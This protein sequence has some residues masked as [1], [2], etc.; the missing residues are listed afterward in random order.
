L[1]KNIEVTV[2]FYGHFNQ[3][4]GELVEVVEAPPGTNVKA[5]MDT[6]SLN[7]PTIWP[8]QST[9]STP[10]D[11]EQ[12]YAVMVNGISVEKSKQSTVTAREGDRITIFLPIS[13]G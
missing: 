3:G 1:K 4:A 7:H 5:V 6:F 9:S 8:D 11:G 2:K 12:T 10:G 13:G